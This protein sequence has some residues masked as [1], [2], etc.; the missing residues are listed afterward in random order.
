MLVGLTRLIF[1]AA[2]VSPPDRSYLA[3]LGEVAPG[4]LPKPSVRKSSN[5]NWWK[6]C[7]LFL[8]PRNPAKSR[9]NQA[10]FLSYGAGFLLVNGPLYD[11]EPKIGKLYTITPLQLEK[12]ISQ[13]CS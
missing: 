12:N 8:L 7:A 13:L 10:A 9:L 4:A 1:G 3:W 6:N 11:V 2:P 5:L